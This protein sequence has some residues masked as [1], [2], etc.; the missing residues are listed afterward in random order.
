MIN[1]KVN[2]SVYRLDDI[3]IKNTTIKAGRICSGCFKEAYH[4]LNYINTHMTKDL[5]YIKKQY[6][7]TGEN[8]PEPE[9]LDHII[10]F[11]ECAINSTKNRA[12]RNVR[13]SSNRNY[14]EDVKGKIRKDYKSQ[15][16]PKIKVKTNKNIIEI[17]GCPPNL[18]ESIFSI[19]KYY[20]KSKT[21]NLSFYNNLIKTY[22]EQNSKPKVKPGD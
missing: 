11:G 8:P 7:L 19:Q 15:K 2:F 12:F 4:L 20:G 17:P 1:L 16:T 14:M 3:K 9:S 10:V 6:F 22:Y 5:K 21:P 13:T 18:Y